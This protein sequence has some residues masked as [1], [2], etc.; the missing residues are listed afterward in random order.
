MAER[1]RLILWRQRRGAPC[2]LRKLDGY[3]INPRVVAFLTLI[4]TD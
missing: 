3:R 1:I 2:R 4:R